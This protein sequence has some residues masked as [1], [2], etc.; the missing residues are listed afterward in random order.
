MTGAFHLVAMQC[1]EAVLK[2]FPVGYIADC[3]E[4]SDVDCRV[5]QLKG[6]PSKTAILCADDFVVDSRQFKRSR[7]F[8]LLECG[9]GLPSQDFVNILLNLFEANVRREI[10]S[11]VAFW[12]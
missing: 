12:A 10:R 1:F 9:V 5:D 8:W 11:K 7:R 4:E 2:K 3:L 6:S